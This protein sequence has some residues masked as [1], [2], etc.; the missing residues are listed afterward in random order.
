MVYLL[1]SPNVVTFEEKCVTTDITVVQCLGKQ[2]RFLTTE[3][4]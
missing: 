3:K 2:G 4:I 1:S